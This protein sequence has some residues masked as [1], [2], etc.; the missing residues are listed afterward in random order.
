MSELTPNLSLLSEPARQFALREHGL[1]INGSFVACDERI[2][3]VDPANGMAITTIARGDGSHVDR[4][5]AAARAAFTDGPWAGLTPAQ[6]SQMIWRLG[7]LVEA[8][9]DELAELESLDN[10]KP[11]SDARAGDVTNAYELLRY[12]A[13]WATRLTG[14]TIPLTQNPAIHA[15]TTREPVG[16]CAQIVPWNFPL[17]MT[18]WKIAPALAAGCTIVLKPSEL[19]SLSALRLAE[20]AQQAGIPDGVFN[21]VTGYG[22]E[23]GAALSA[24]RDVDK[25]AFTG[26]TAVG[27][28]I[29]QAAG[30]N[31][32]KVSLEL[33][34][35]SPMI[36]LADADLDRA[37]PAV[38]AGIFYNMGQTCTA[39]TRLYVHR[40]ISRQVHARLAEIARGLKIGIGLDPATR[41]GPLISAAQQEK[42]LGYIAS[43]LEQGARLVCGGKADGDRGYFVQPT[44]LADTKPH[45]RVV[46]EEIFGP[47]LVTAEFDDVDEAIAMAND[48]IYGLAGSIFTRDVSLAHQLVRQ[49]KSGI[50]GVNTHHVVDPALPFGGFRQSGW[51]REMGWAAME[52]YTET[53]SVGIAL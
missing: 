26:S 45:M 32:K 9:A 30:G 38:A 14:Q 47:V 22:P 20:L 12:M 48:S 39:G 10:G 28:T 15:Y 1:F 5:V 37:I 53:K 25:I 24:H 51:G 6:R 42:V 23:V 49:L 35:K 2:A 40:S 3:V 52:L 21:V 43:G 16:V 17:M 44:I 7:D 27:K 33:G 31:L 34:G 11:V 13:G 19:T 50:I 4:A 41:I 18:V 8:H 36:L 46:Q 29:L